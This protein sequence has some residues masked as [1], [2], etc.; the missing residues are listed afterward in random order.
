MEVSSYRTFY[1]IQRE[2][3]NVVEAVGVADV[4]GGGRPRLGRPQAAADHQKVGEADPPQVRPGQQLY[5]GQ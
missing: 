5:P 4:A 3:E 1:L 2:S